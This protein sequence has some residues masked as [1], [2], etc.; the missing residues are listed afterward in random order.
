MA[1]SNALKKEKEYTPEEL[2]RN[3]Q[4]ANSWMWAY[5]NKLRIS[6]HPY[7][8][9]GHEYQVDWFFE[10]NPRQC[11]KKGAQIGA[12]EVNV[13]K[14]VHGMITGKYDQGAL[15][16]FPTRDDV[17]DFSKA[18][19]EP[20]I[21]ENPTTVLPYVRKTDAA[22]IKRIGNSML[23]LR[24]ARARETLGGIKRTSSALKSIPVDKVVFDEVDEMEQTMVDL[25]KERLSHSRVQEEIYLSTPTIPDY[26]ISA[27][28]DTSDQR[29]W[30]IECEH[31]GKET[32][33][34]LE[35][36]D[37]LQRNK[38]DTV[39]RVC[40]KCRKPVR[41][42]RGK[43]RPLYPD[44]SK[45]MVGW[46]ISQLCSKF[47][48]PKKI[49]DLFED[50][51]TNLGEF[52]NSK[53]GMPY[54]PSENRL[55]RN[56]LWR[57]CE[58][59]PMLTH[60]SGPTCM[61][62]DVGKQLHVVVGDK[63]KQDVLR[64]IYAARVSSFNDVHDIARRFAVKCAVMDLEPETRKVR[65]FQSAEPY[66]VFLCDYS[67]FQRGGPR[68]DYIKKM[69]VVNRTEVC[70]AT[71]DLVVDEGRFMLP[72]KGEELTEYISEMCN[73]AKVRRED[74]LSGSVKYKYIKLG[75]DHYRHATNYLWLASH[76]VGTSG[77]K[78]LKM[79]RRK[80]RPKVSHK[81]W[82]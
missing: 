52:Y 74:E 27:L 76:E 69:V 79:F 65:E 17:T 63:P 54:I 22:N 16:L 29:V 57:L 36:P 62:V 38:D 42:N 55:T 2:A 73:I 49:L 31:C 58:S 9:K 21:S 71:H 5:E 41:L 26:G 46:W 60:H 53:L 50:P 78:F 59:D 28:F 81:G 47:V 20:L 7:E 80:N 67:D 1:K 19:F 75:A 68:W 3:A 44:R 40:I 4:V 18:R 37:C 23:Y 77:D 15:Y 25:A 11:F 35:F 70:D 10:E 61:G 14:T 32:S 13:I 48:D 8:V 82:T 6:G 43:W 24:G 56:D 12:T 72:R 34:E 45:D 33:L 66:A 51:E 39:D 64:L 30:M